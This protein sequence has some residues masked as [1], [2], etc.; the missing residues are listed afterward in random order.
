MG[1]VAIVAGAFAGWVASDLYNGIYTRTGI[2][3]MLAILGAGAVG[4]MDDWIKVVRSRN[5]GLNKRTKMIGLFTVAI[6][7]SLLMAWHT[8]V[9]TELSFTRF[10][11]AAI[12]LGRALWVVW[13]VFLITGFANAVNLT[14][15]LDGLASGSA[16]L[17]YAAY[18]FIAFWQFRHEGVYGVPHA[19]DL[20]VISAAM[21]GGCAGFLWW[22]A[23]PARIF[24]G[25]TGSLAIGT[26]LAA[27]SLA[28]N[29]HLLLLIIGGLFVVET[30]SVILQVLR[31]RLTGRRFFRM[32]P[33]HH[34]LELGGWPE[35]TVI[36]RLWLVSG[37]CTAV[38][39]G[40]FYA[41]AIAAG[42]TR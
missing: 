8:S 28:T 15:G 3:V 40:F 6:G 39:L 14:D 29:T 31:F 4:L 34:H 24:M 18:M 35:T 42:I 9:H 2:F 12:A 19:L 26:G 36:I 25:D 17:A 32:A 33:F 10:D 23:P 38:G 20:A 13:A 22:N 1:G 7:F 11:S 37:L 41:D 16:I 30:L 27:L 5:L 21:L